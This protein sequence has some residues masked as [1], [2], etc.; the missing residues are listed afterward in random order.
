MQCF[1]SSTP[2]SVLLAEEYELEF[3]FGT[4]LDEMDFV[5]GIVK[6]FVVLFVYTGVEVTFPAYHPN[7]HILTRL[8]KASGAKSCWLAIHVVIGV[9]GHTI[10]Y[11]QFL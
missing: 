4:K 10:S 2:L 6:F 8:A 9:R 5:G 3:A 1:L 7:C 11:D